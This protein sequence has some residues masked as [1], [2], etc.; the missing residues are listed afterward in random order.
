MREQV[1]EDIIDQQM[2]IESHYPE[3]PIEPLVVVDNQDCQGDDTC[4][5][6]GR[7]AIETTRVAGEAC[8]VEVTD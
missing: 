7:E 3:G 5:E 6:G 4:S 8:M 1:D 2:T